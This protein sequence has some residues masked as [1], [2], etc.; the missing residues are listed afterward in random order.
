[1]RKRY[2]TLNCTQEE[3][4]YRI[5][6]H[7]RINP[8]KGIVEENHFK[9]Y[10]LTPRIFFGKGMQNSLFCFYGE[11]RQSGDCT[12]VSYR[13]RPDIPTCLTFLVLTLVTL[14]QIYC[15]IFVNDPFINPILLLAIEVLIYL[16]TFHEMK[17]CIEDFETQ[18]TSKIK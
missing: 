2:L 4:E 17:K 5:K 1:M 11:Y 6:Q 7:L 15:A 12:H 13:I 10:M 9:I 3:T 18:L 8:P 14:Y 16:L